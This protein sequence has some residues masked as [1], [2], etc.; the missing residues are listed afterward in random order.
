[1]TR[2]LVSGFLIAAA[3]L[4]FGAQARAEVLLTPEMQNKLTLENLTRSAPAPRKPQPVQSQS[5]TQSNTQAHVPAHAQ[6]RLQ[7]VQTQSALGGMRRVA[8]NERSLPHGTQSR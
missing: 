7:T 4:V 6:P 5:N 1:M 2:R 3:L 8:G